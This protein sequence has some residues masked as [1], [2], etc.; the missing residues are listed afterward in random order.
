MKSVLNNITNNFLIE[1]I[2]DR[3]SYKLRTVEWRYF[4]VPS[5]PSI[6]TGDIKGIYFNEIYDGK[7]S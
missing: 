3:F 6:F 7:F 2:V 1:K 5:N 4:G